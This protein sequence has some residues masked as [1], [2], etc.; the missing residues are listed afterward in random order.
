MRVASFI[1]LSPISQIRTHTSSHARLGANADRSCNLNMVKVLKCAS[2]TAAG[3]ARRIAAHHQISGFREQKTKFTVPG[4][5]SGDHLV[6]DLVP[7][8]NK[9][10]S[11]SP[12]TYQHYQLQASDIVHDYTLQRLEHKN[13]C[14]QKLLDEC[15]LSKPGSCKMLAQCGHSAPF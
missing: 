5:Y 3:V 4:Q 11:Y 7:D 12:V 8:P 14:N 13:F 1:S 9:N 15:K 10:F 6:K 2:S